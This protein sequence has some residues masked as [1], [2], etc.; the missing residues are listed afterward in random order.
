MAKKD[1]LY[2]MHIHEALTK[3]I[4]YTDDVDLSD[5]KENSLIQDGV[6]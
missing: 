2:L 5:F 1:D 4:R 6:I 3:I